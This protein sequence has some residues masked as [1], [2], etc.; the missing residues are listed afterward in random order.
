[1]NWSLSN[2]TG[3]VVEA[4]AATGLVV[5][6]VAAPPPPTAPAAACLAASATVT[7]VGGNYTLDG[8]QSAL[9]VGDGV[10]TL[11][12]PD[13]Y[14]INVHDSAGGCVV[15][16]VAC[17][18][19]CDPQAC[20]Q[21]PNVTFCSGTT[22]WRVPAS[23]AGRTLSLWCGFHGAMGGADRLPFAPHCSMASPPSS[24]SPA[25]P[26]PAPPSPHHPWT[27]SGESGDYIDPTWTGSGE[28]GDYI[29]PTW[30]GSGD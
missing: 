30:T 26:A 2:A 11:Q 15:E 17:Q 6:A 4:V 19:P 22:S 3:F 18:T 12:V 20:T 16:N 25:S 10:Y 28:S 13:S 23:C 8:V 1:L 21:D 27:G 14:P 5:E 29:D 7:A 9:A 24:P